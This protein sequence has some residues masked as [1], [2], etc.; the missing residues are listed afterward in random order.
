MFAAMFAFVVAGV[1]VLLSYHGYFAHNLVAP[2]DRVYAATIKAG[3]SGDVAWS[4]A[5]WAIPG[6]LLQLLGGPKRQMGVLFATGPTARR[7]W[8]RAGSARCGIVLRLVDRGAAARRADMEVFAAG[9][10]AG[11][12]FY[13]FY[14]MGSKYAAL[15]K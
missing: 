3:I 5:L 12:A 9:V 4:L 8:A 1:V 14:D 15:K 2:V 10:I 6:A 13:S 7:P 11:D